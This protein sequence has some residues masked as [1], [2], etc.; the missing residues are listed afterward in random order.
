MTKKKTVKKSAK[1]AHRARSGSD[2]I[3]KLIL[4][5]HKPLKQLIKVM[6]N[7]DKEYSERKNAFEKF[8]ELLLAHA[9]PEE[10]A[11]Y[12]FMKGAV[13]MRTEA[14]EGDVEHM[15]ADQLI[16][17][18]KLTDDEDIWSARV[19]VL[20][21]LVEHHIEEEE[22][23]MLPDFRKETDSEERVILGQKYLHYRSK[24]ET[25]GGH[26]RTSRSIDNRVH[27]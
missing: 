14:F 8:S 11:L 22:E 4:D 10:Q 5:D 21:E 15:I 1:P 25:A 2:D 20:A 3:V 7:T 9:K 12:E 18:V 6:K 23:D 13:D 27:H 26:A 16:E 19:K 17:Q 24:Y